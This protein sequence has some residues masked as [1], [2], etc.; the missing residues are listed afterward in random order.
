M[1]ALGDVLRLLTN[2]GFKPTYAKRPRRSFIGD[3][4]CA[5][6]RISVRLSIEDWDFF[7]YPKI[8]LLARPAFLPDLLP[9]CDIY[10][11][12]C[13]FAPKSVTL[14][15]Y[16]PATAIEQCLA[17]ATCL[18]DHIALDS[19]YRAAD[20]ELEFQA[21]WNYGQ[22]EQPLTVL[23]GDIE[24]NANVA[25]Y[26]LMEELNRKSFLVTS[27]IEQ[28]TQ[29]SNAMGA[30]LKPLRCTCWLMQ[31]GKKPPTTERMPTTVKELM[32]WLRKWDQALSVTMQKVLGEK[33]Y[34]RYQ[35]VTFA[36]R[37]PVGW[38][39][40]GFDLNQMKR[41]AYAR[42]PKKYRNYLH[43]VGGAQPIFRVALQEVGGRFVHNRNLSFPDLYNKR[44]TLVG[45]GA[46]GSFLANA[47]TRLGAGT[48]KLGQLKLIDSDTL[49][50]EN[51]GRHT[52][53]YPGLK[54]PKSDALCKNLSEQ[55]PFSRFQ[56]VVADVR[57]HKQLF[58]A[59]LLIDA[60]GEEQ[61]CEYLN[62]LRLNYHA[63]VPVLHVWIR[64]NGEAVQAFWADSQSEAC[65]RCLLVPDSQNHRKQRFRLLKHAVERRTDGCRAYTPYAVSAPMEAAALA[66]DMV[67]DWLNGNPSPRFRTRSRENADVFQVKNQNPSKMLGCPA[68]DP[69]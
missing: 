51:L 21:H 58:A 59:D 22:V 65:Y 69:H 38:V 6:G 16:D 52:L 27:T 17:Q 41:I 3:L 26:F 5:K 25:E 36:I 45:C 37:T 31:T 18:L 34:L 60:T 54:K 12:L 50:P 49:G 24:P 42:S 39:G 11:D 10:G 29:L 46:I 7:E 68:C 1:T 9:H 14:D 28:A 32:A 40:F 48:G 55:F 63:N 19:E 23:L 2:L 33:E 57:V 15:R 13:Y 30:K 43:K 20:I 56:A 62:D 61:V 4:R 64:G 67:C 35:L 66:T 8:T 53:G 44:V 47:L